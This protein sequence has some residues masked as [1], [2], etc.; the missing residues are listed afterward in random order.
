M[1]TLQ[2]LVQLGELN[3]CAIEC[4]RQSGWKDSTQRYLANLLLNNLELQTEIL[5]GTYRQRPTTDFML[6]E[7]GH[8][9]KIEAPNIRDRVIQ[10]SIMENVLIPAI[11]PCLIY[12]NY[13]SLT[14]RGTAFARKRFEALM[15]RYIQK[16]G[17]DGYILLIDIRKYF[18]NIDHQ[19][20]KDMVAP[21]LKD[22]PQNVVDLV[23]YIIDSS[24]H[25]DKGLNL[26]SECPQI[27]AVYYLNPIDQYIKTVRGIK[28]Y[29]RYMDDIFI[30]GKTKQELAAILQNIR[31]ILAGLRLEINEKKTHVV[32]ISHGF[33]FLQV[34]YSITSTGH[35]IKRPSHG[36]ILRERRRLKAFRRRLNQRRM[37]EH[38]IWDCYQSWRG[39][40]IS[41]H[42]A[43][44]HSLVSMDRLYRR[45]FPSHTSRR[46]FTRSFISRY[47]NRN[48]L[49]SHLRHARYEITP[50]A[51][52]TVF[53]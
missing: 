30:I 37:T 31:A 16:N 17:T 44:H 3:K 7:R 23:N 28:Y 36:K 26:G 27:F 46:K 49:P 11:R 47:I 12:D 8:I 25:S 15:H 38:D 10:K 52:G 2:E 33:T 22:Q 35:I 48:T 29:G 13:A 42:N 53:V 18:E 21:K 43:C 24:S 14:K 5:E 4:T 40:L 45:L 50:F 9:R 34:K 1:A 32:R 41:D 19:V 20:L 39:T 51:A 6:N